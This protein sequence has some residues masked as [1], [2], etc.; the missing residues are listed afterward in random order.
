MGDVG[1][2]VVDMKVESIAC[3]VDW[4]EKLV[5]GERRHAK[6]LK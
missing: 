3:R 6:I 1:G 4:R 2:G 5:V